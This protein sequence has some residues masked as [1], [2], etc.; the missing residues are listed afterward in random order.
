[1]IIFKESLIFLKKNIWIFLCLLLISFAFYAFRN[2]YRTPYDNA[3]IQDLYDHSQWTMPISIRSIGD[4]KLYQLAGYISVTSGNLFTINPEAPPLAK[5]LYGFSILLTN[6]AYLF[7]IPLFLIAIFLVYKLAFEI[8]QNKKQ[9]SLA[10][11]LFC[12]SPLAI[13]QIKYTMLDLPQLLTFLAHAYMLMRYG[14]T[15]RIIF[16]L[17]SGVFFGAFMGTKIGF[18]GLAILMADALYLY[19][20]K[21]LSTMLHIIITSILVYIAVFIPYI[22]REGILQWLRA[23]KWVLWFYLSSNARAFPGL[24]FFALFGGITKGWNTND[25]WRFVEYW[26]ILWPFMGVVFLAKL[27]NLLTRKVTI[28]H[29]YLYALCVT[30][31]LLTSFLVVPF[32]PRYLLLTLPFFLIFISPKINRFSARSKI[33][34]S[35]ILL[36]QFVLFLFPQP[37]SMIKNVENL[38]EIGVYQ[39]LYSSLDKQTQRSTNRL[40]FWR[41]GKNIEHDLHLT[42]KDITISIPFFVLPWENRVSTGASIRYTTPVGPITYNVPLTLLRENNE[43]KIRWD[44]NFFYPR[45]KTYQSIRYISIPSTFSRIFIQETLISE[46]SGKQI[47]YVTPNKIRDENLLQGQLF[48]LT[49]LKK[50]D[51]EHI[52]KANNLPEKMVEIGPVLDTLVQEK[53]IGKLDPGITFQIRNQRIFYPERVDTETYSHTIKL[54]RLRNENLYPLDGGYIQLLHKDRTTQKLLFREPAVGH[55]IIL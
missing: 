42:S 7:N 52:Y 45:L 9:A 41:T 47:V 24:V 43:W 44:E 23:E 20:M 14:K 54:L 40:A 34:L 13:A 30:T 22:L 27:W 6:N 10:C 37:S 18:F 53:S 51:V 46:G 17:L 16:A 55:D 1:M 28:T 31:L 39:D 5:Y 29:E 26:T 50:H 3:Y 35:I 25:A 11:L 21:C 49:G 15:K 48:I 2:I 38:W 12:M 33:M 36:T 8:M 4:E 32:F 19:K